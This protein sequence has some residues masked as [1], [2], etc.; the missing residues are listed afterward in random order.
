MM[1]KRLCLQA[2]L[3]LP[4]IY[5]PLTRAQEVKT[6]EAEAVYSYSS[7]ETYNQAK[8]KAYE[9]AVIE[10]VNKAFPGTI[11]IETIVIDEN[12]TKKNG[13][14]NSTSKFRTVTS[15]EK[16]G[17][18][19]GDVKEPEYG[20]P[21][22]DPESGHWSFTCKVKGKVRDREKVN[23][24]HP[25]FFW[26]LLRNGT[27]DT[28]EDSNFYD[29]DRLYMKFAAPCDGYLAVYLI[30]GKD[31][32]ECL[33]PHEKEPEG[34]YKVKGG[35]QYTFFSPKHRNDDGMISPNA[36]MLY[37]YGEVEYCT[38]Y[39]LFSPNKFRQVLAQGE[40]TKDIE[41]KKYDMVPMTSINSFQKWMMNL[42]VNDN[43]MQREYK[44]ITITLRDR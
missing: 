8:K 44:H 29:Y 28:A 37:P 35:K 42:L 38:V 4:F 14:I 18:Y 32:V 15:F 16:K 10:A 31:S 22:Y 30:N 41:G 5:T 11:A 24:A 3:F 9:M 2:F 6:V 7:D 39:V 12:E 26:K 13:K 34:I 19:L 33:I 17:V 1:I 40:E 43:E 21:Q 20:I 23:K 27:D 36:L 25:S